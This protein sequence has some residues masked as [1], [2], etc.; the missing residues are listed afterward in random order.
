MASPKLDAINVQFSRKIGDAVASAST[1]GNILS[2]AERDTYINLALNEVFRKY[3]ELVQGNS[4]KF[5]EIFPELHK[6]L[7]VTTTAGGTFVLAA[8]NSYDFFK[9][10]DAYTVT[11][12]KYIKFLEKTL[13]TVVVTGANTLYTPSA[14]HLVG[15]EIEG[16]LEFYPAASFNAQNVKINYIRR[17]VDPANGNAFS[18]G[19]TNDIPFYSIWSEEIAET[20]YR[21]WRTN[22]QE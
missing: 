22:Q 17:P 9:M 16:T 21:I 6:S 13:R 1:A 19:G 18:N 20:A 7:Q 5:L 8:A 11:S 3:W 4:E 10:I 12:P 14:D 2:A 15:F